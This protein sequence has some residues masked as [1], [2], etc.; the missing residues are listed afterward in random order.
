MVHITFN[1]TLS[2]IKISHSFDV[3][4]I[5]KLRECAKTQHR[6]DFEAKVFAV[7]SIFLKFVALFYRNIF[8][9]GRV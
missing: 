9:I 7:M 5:L 2:G 8:L 6:H 3:L 1:E 4:A